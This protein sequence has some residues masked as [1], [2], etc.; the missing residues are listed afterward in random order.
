MSFIEKIEQSS[1]FKKNPNYFEFFKF[2]I[3]GVAGTVVDFGIYSILK[4]I[5]GIYYI[6][7]TAI[8]VFLAILNNFY[9]NKYWTFK[10]G[11]SGKTKIEYVRFFIV[12]ITNY[13]LNIG[14]TYYIVEFTN[15]ES[16]FGNFEDYFAKAVAIAIV[17]FGNYFG[18]KFWTFKA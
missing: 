3:V 5:F 13:F 16:I 12:S 11:K 9:L 8:S 15:F 7:A 1:F 6:F 2:S 10:R 14:I 18:N 4:N 17:L